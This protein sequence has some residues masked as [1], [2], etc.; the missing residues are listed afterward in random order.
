MKNIKV[1]DTGCCDSLISAVKK[2]I[3]SKE[4]SD[5]YGITHVTDLPEIY[6]HGV[7]ELPALVID[8]ET[9]IVVGELNNEQVLEKLDDVL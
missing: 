6:K 5:K 9:V 7:T 4:N 2:H 8:D 1:L 3:A